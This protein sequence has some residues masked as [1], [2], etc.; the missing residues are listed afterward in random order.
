MTQFPIDHVARFAEHLADRAHSVYG[1]S[2]RQQTRAELPEVD[3]ERR[4]LLG[5]LGSS[6][7]LSAPGAL[8]GINGASA[9]VTGGAHGATE[10]QSAAAP[11][12]PLSLPLL[13]E[14]YGAAGNEADDDAQAFAA[15]PA[16]AGALVGPGTYRIGSNV[17]I[18]G[19]LWFMPGAVLRPHA[20]ATVA[21][22]PG[23]S[24]TAGDYWIF[25]NSQGGAFRGTEV[26]GWAKSSW[27]PGGASRDLGVQLNN[28]FRWGFLQVDVP[29][30]PDHT[31]RT[32]VKLPHGSTVR[33]MWHNYPQ[34][35]VCATNDKPVFE[36]VGGVRH[37]R[38]IGGVFD[39][40]AVNTPSCF[41]LCGRD[42]ATLGQCG[43]TTALSEVQVSGHWGI[44][45]IVN[46]AGEVLVFQNCNLWI[47]GRG[48]AAWSGH[49]ATVTIANA[50]YWG[51]PFAYTKPTVG[52]G[53]TSAIV[54]QNCDIRGGRQ[55][56]LNSS[57]FYLKGQVEDLSIVA[58]YL[59]GAGRCQIL[60]EPAT[61]SS[62]SPRRIYLGGGGRTENN[63]GIVWAGCPTVLVDGQGR[64]GG[65][66]GLTIGPMGHFIGGGMSHSTPILKTENTGIIY[67]LTWDQG[68]H[69]EH[70]NKLIEHRTAD[71][72]WASIRSRYN[73]EIDCT[74]RTISDSMIK[75]HGNLR[76]TVGLKSKVHSANQNNW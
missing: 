10:G 55:G 57:T 36:A 29:P 23:A 30:A 76:G 19:H 70:T 13:R 4:Y 75:I 26:T 12:Y 22:D 34:H 14:S 54:F 58:T 21:W 43:D 73:A 61:G 69:V 11:R 56:V 16:G 32:T 27:F 59:N 17:Q 9:A 35:I 72:Q 50:D 39:G 7:L 45:N 53:S 38:I 60:C 74:G 2:V 65:V 66:F 24:V 49:Q 52:G 42:D 28:A 40:A 51:I 8:A 18:R 48:D 33:V 71:L 44:G 6:L 31:I 68:M 5:V 25:D 63:I 37:W 46:I 41:L 1:C 64:G 62:K 3:G 20:G 67:D 15:V 47:Q